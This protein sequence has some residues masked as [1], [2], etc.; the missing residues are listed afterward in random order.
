M[1]T[2]K[3]PLL[4]VEDLSLGFQQGGMRLPVLRRVTFDVERGEVLALVGESG[5]GKSLTAL[6][7][8]G[9][10]PDAARIA[11]GSVRLAECG[12]LLRLPE[13]R[14]RRV[15]GRRIAMIFQEPMSALNPV[16][17]IGFQIAEPLRLHRGLGR[18]EARRE[19]LRLLDLVAMPD[20]QRRL[21]SYPY[22]LS[23]GQQQRAMIAMALASEPEILIADEPTTAL[24]VTVQRQVLELLLELRRQLGLTVMLITHDLGLVAQYCDRVAVM[25]A[26]QIVE[27]A[28]VMALF[29][30]PAHPYTR[31]LLDAVPR[32][33]G[34]S[35]VRCRAIP[36]QVPEPGATPS[37]CAFAP[38]CPS[39]M[40]RCESREPELC[41]MAP[42]AAHRSRCFLHAGADS[43]ESTG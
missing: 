29:E 11:G 5:C 30:Q 1:T 10:L 43:E 16:L 42:G 7:I 32:L 26:G 24:D 40:E 41:E 39:V 4:A 20:P 6:A 37:G 22:Q 28:P 35:G 25:Y 19:A 14:R 15:R 33:D 3:A 34:S 23:G 8:L 13:R 27:Q 2:T 12:D 38:R 18:R 17:S 36:G 9:L 21:S 31:A